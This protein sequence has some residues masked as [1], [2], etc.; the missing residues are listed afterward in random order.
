MLLQASPCRSVAYLTAH[1]T[2]KQITKIMVL[3]NENFTRFFKLKLHIPSAQTKKKSFL[4]TVEIICFSEGS[5][6]IIKMNDE[7]LHMLM[8]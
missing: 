7:R 3:K 2:E 1:T 6:L 5:L 4:N 8:I